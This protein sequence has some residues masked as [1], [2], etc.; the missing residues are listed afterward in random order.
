MN[1]VYSLRLRLMLCKKFAGVSV[2]KNR[3][4]L[5]QQR[6]YII[7]Q[8]IYESDA[9]ATLPF[10]LREKNMPQLNNRH[11]VRT[12][13]TQHV[14]VTHTRKTDSS[15]TKASW[16][17]GANKELLSKQSLL[18]IGML[19]Q[20]TYEWFLSTVDFA[21]VPP[22]DW[23]ARF[24][25]AKRPLKWVSSGVASVVLCALSLLI[26]LDRFLFYRSNP[27]VRCEFRDYRRH[28]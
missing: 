12:T 11:F 24:T 19:G 22:V 21:A 4:I 28:V 7:V 8:K 10:T 26:E 20:K 14:Y 13:P 18:T 23:Q 17:V 1:R 6:D 3:N 5:L 15:Y 9:S 25:N 16:V 27:I 2:S